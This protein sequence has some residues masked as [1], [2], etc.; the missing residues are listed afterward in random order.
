MDFMATKGLEYLLIFAYL[1]LLVPF[2]R[3]LMTSERGRA[4]RSELDGGHG[5]R[6]GLPTR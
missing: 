3:L 1:I 5:H 4:L 6:R 2:W